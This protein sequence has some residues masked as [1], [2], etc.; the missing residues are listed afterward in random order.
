MA[1]C[2]LGGAAEVERP[3][4]G[5]RAVCNWAGEWALGK[6]RR[7]VRMEPTFAGAGHNMAEPRFLYFDLGNVLVNFSVQRMVRQMAE[8]AGIDLQT[9]EDVVFARG[10]QGEY[11]RGCISSEEFY[12]LFCDH[13]GT[14]PDYE[15]LLRAGNEIFD[16]NVSM[17]PVVG[18]LE[19]AGYRLG[20]LSNTCEGHWRY[21][22]GRFPILTQSFSIHAVSFRIG[23]VKPEAAIFR[24]AAEMAGV[25]PREVF[26]VDDMPGHVA[27]AKS[28]GFDA[29]QYTSTAELVAEL[30]GRG[31]RFNY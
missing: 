6:G 15:A 1:G 30:R 14:R 19:Q 10:L 5:R 28:V 3:G 2:F 7:F 16:L 25:E 12:Q 21:V 4:G 23:A 17:L 8:A 9:V 31:L 22:V 13:T 27:G 24:A 26:F 20:I 29:V 11:E 18:Q